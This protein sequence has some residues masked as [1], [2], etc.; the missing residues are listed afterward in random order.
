L[1]ALHPEI[2]ADGLTAGQINALIQ[3]EAPGRP[4]THRKMR[5]IVELIKSKR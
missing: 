4:C 5:E 3:R 1:K 2:L